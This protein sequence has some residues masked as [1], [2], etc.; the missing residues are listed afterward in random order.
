MKGGQY[1]W[2]HS[3][4]RFRFAEESHPSDFFFNFSLF[5]LI[6]QHTYEISDLPLRLHLIEMHTCI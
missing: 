1:N 3:V 5:I 6:L 4:V 2:P